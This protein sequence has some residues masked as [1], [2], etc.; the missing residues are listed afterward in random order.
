MAT[1]LTACWVD[2]PVSNIDAVYKE[3]KKMKN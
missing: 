2:K 1:R 3:L